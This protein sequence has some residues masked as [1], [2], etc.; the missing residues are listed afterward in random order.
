MLNIYSGMMAQQNQE[1]QLIRSEP[2]LAQGAAAANRLSGAMGYNPDGS[3]DRSS[4]LQQTFSAP[5]QDQAA[6]TPGYGFTLDQG[7]R[8]VQNSA[9]ARG[10]GTSGAAIKGAAGYATGLAD[11][12]YNDVYSRALGTFNA[13]YNAAAG[14]VGRLQ[15]SMTVGANTNTGVGTNSVATSGLI[16]QSANNAATANANGL[17]GSSAANASG[18]NSIGNALQ[19]YGSTNNASTGANALQTGMA[20]MSS[21]P[22]GSLN[23]IKGWTS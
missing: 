1:N 6:A 9:A 16:G 21:D 10:L 13:N 15:Q 18:L 20:N 22:I 12:T 19:T 4:A 11:S 17:V 5:T 2:Y 7:L 8:A 23:S 14:N 3:I